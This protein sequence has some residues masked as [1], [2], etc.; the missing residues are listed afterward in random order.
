M[1]KST[2]RVT[3]PELIKL[4]NLEQEAKENPRVYI[5]MQLN[6]DDEFH[7]ESAHRSEAG[8]EARRAKL[9][10][11]HGIDKDEEDQYFSIE[12]RRLID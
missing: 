6:S 10:L 12:V 2:F 11:E 4:H 1:S 5:L 7:V 8:A 3:D 9:A